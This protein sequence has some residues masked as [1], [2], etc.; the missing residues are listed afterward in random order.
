MWW[1]WRV[2]QG[3][4]SEAGRCPEWN[5]ILWSLCLPDNSESR[6][7]S[8]GSHQ[9]YDLFL[10]FSKTQKRI[11]HLEY[12][13]NL[14]VFYSDQIAQKYTIAL[15]YYFVSWF[16]SILQGINVVYS[17]SWN[18]WENTRCKPSLK[19]WLCT[20]RRHLKTKFQR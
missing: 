4:S 19:S 20:F 17:Y 9:V 13:W 7:V 8:L 3:D 18:Q 15:V 12:V 1:G 10:F 14:K 6:D 2:S 11:L 16:E 5:L